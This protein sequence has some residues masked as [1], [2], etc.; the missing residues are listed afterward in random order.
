[1][2]APA[3]VSRPSVTLRIANECPVKDCTSPKTKTPN[4]TKTGDS[5]WRWTCTSTEHPQEVWFHGPCFNCSI[6]DTSHNRCKDCNWHICR[7]CEACDKEGCSRNNYGTIK[8][9]NGRKVVEADKE[10]IAW[11]IEN[12]PKLKDP[13][14]AKDHEEIERDKIRY[15][16]TYNGHM[17]PQELGGA[18]GEYLKQQNK[19][20]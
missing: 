15:L 14:H 4:H 2:V 18:I 12:M 3:L 13:I 16:H 17:E 1:M 5:M 19:S 8:G 7:H 10:V 11:L 6:T 9:W 20:S